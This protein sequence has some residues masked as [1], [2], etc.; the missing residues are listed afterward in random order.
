M[1][2]LVTKFKYLKP[3]ARINRGGYAKYIGSREGVEKIDDTLKL[4]P[5]TLKQKQLIRKLLSDFPDT[6]EMLEYEDYLAEPCRGNAAEFITRAI[7]DNASGGV[8]QPTYADY[9]ATRPGVEHLGSHGLFTDEG[10][11][12]K[13]G[14]VSEEMNQHEGNVWTAIISLRREDAVRLGYDSGNRWRDMLR[15]QASTLAENLKIP[16]PHLRWYAAFHNE[17][18]HPHVHLIAYSSKAGEGYLTR[19]G[20]MNLRSA[21]G[22]DIF[23]QDLL[24]VYQKQT[25]YR[26]ELRAAGKQQLN[27]IIRQIQSGRYSNHKVRDA[28]LHLARHL[29]MTS[30]KKVYGYLKPDLKRMVDDFV[31]EIAKDERIAALYDLWYEQKEETFRT[32]SQEIPER[33]PLQHNPEFHVIKNAVIREAQKLTDDWQV[34]EDGEA[35]EELDGSSDRYPVD[36]DRLPWWSKRYRDARQALYGRGKIQPDYETA[37]ALLKAESE[38]GNGFAMYDLGK[39]YLSRLG[40]ETDEVS[41]QEWFRKAHDA[42]IQEAK[43]HRKKDYLQ[44]RIGKLYSLGHG[45]GQDFT[46]AAEWF[47][48]AV[49]SGNPFAAYSLGSLYLRGQ[50]VDKDESK[51]Q[52]LFLNAATH[53]KCP[54]GYAMYE[55]GKL[56]DGDES[57][58]WY[59]KAYLQFS[60]LESKNPDDKLQYRLGQ[61]ALHGLGV[62]ANK[63]TAAV[64]FLKATLLKNKDATY[65]L[66]KLYLDTEFSGFDAAQG[67]RLLEKSVEQHKNM[68]AAYLL[69]KL[70]AKGVLVERNVSKALSYLRMAAEENNP[71][72]LYRLGVMYYYGDGVESDREYARTLLSASADL[73]NEYA[74]QF[75]TKQEIRDALNE[76]QRAAAATVRLFRQIGNI[77]RTEI[78][79]DPVGTRPVADRKLLRKIA[80]KKELHGERISQ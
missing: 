7:E 71:F 20:V 59:R 30:G 72:A 57:K 15:S 40:I 69:G 29:E 53:K 64:Y 76:S 51:A 33:V 67:V 78:G 58:E 63:K 80:L 28:L 32:Y 61:M 48:K 25:E 6:K 13:L 47:E 8:D 38:A 1:A 14:A 75:L 55:L 60:S 17:S 56:S 31:A 4:E 66:G 24:S 54:N 22:R 77:L 42:F 41:A 9:I 49:P 19:Q 73:G 18:H 26:D 5:A 2:K 70:Y 36:D 79:D 39:L 34:P 52:D 27:E 46:K 43:R 3:G 44:Y 16:L 11:R 68:N 45:V 10:V 65:A 12:V 74:R 50:G 37:H 23:A 21:I 35:V 62:E